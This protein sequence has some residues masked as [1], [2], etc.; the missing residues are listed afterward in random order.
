[1]SA[2]FNVLAFPDYIVTSHKTG[3]GYYIFVLAYTSFAFFLIAPLVAWS[4]NFEKKKQFEEE[5]ALASEQLQAAAATAAVTPGGKS[6]VVH[7]NATKPQPPGKASSNVM[8][9]SGNKSVAVSSLS[10][11]SLTPSHFSKVSKNTARSGRSAGFYFLRELDKVAAAEYP[12]KNPDFQSHIGGGHTVV[13]KSGTADTS[14]AS[15][16]P[17]AATTSR[18]HLPSPS[19]KN[20]SSLVLDVGGRRWKNRR[21]IGRVDVIHHAIHHERAGSS[22]SGI[23]NSKQ[24]HSTPGTRATTSKQHH[25][26]RPGSKGMSDIASSVLSEQTHEIMRPNSFLHPPLTSMNHHHRNRFI[27]RPSRSG[28]YSAASERSALS[29]IVDD[30]SPNDAADANDPGRGN[31]FVQDENGGKLIQQSTNSGLRLGHC[32]A[33][34]ESLLELTHPGEEMTRVVL[35]SFPLAMGAM[36]EAF[37]RLVTATFISQYLGTES[38]IAFLLVGLF[39]RLTSEELSGAIIDALSSFV[40]TC[41]FSEEGD[42]ARMAGQFVQHAVFLQLVLGIPLLLVWALSMEDVVFWLVQSTTI[43]SVAN[44]YAQVVVFYYLVQSLSRTCTVV[45]HICG[46]EHFESI[47]DFATSTM[48]LIVVAFVVATVDNATLMTVGYIQVLIGI[49]GAVAKVMFPVMRGWMK[50]FRGGMIGELAIIRSPAALKQLARA[51]VPLFLGT[52]LEY[53]EWEV[54][55]LFLRHLGPAEVATWA[56]LGA[57]WDVLE[58]MTEG[59]GEAA[60]IQVTFLLAAAQPERARKLANSAI[61][62]AVVQAMVVTS[63]LYMGGR[64]LAVLFSSDYTIQH[65]LNNTIALI[66]LANVTMSFSQ[67]SWSLIGAQGRF[68]LA[69]SVFFFSRWIVTIPLALVTIF[70]F[71]LDLN[72]VSG[73]LVVGYSTASC[74]LTFIVL[75]SD[76]ERLARVMQDMN[77][78]PEKGPLDMLDGGDEDND[79]GD[80]FEDF[81]DDSDS[82]D[83]FGI[84]GKFD[85]DTIAGRSKAAQESE[86]SGRSKR[87]KQGKDGSAMSLR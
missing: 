29:S 10:G 41:L 26:K 56:L 6:K 18:L 63:G 87:S 78:A 47:I 72:S 71:F 17:S 32:S 13:S 48:Q 24:G 51:V 31:I 61:Y 25:R 54:L 23:S 19:T 11:G 83:G 44:D 38:M 86:V 16:S 84:G 43:A 57:I 20:L 3:P 1:M 53:G 7:T 5:L 68:R 69:T 64:Y 66:G 75:R 82:S 79:D 67:I 21:P 74:A 8:S 4:R 55:T 34:F 36:S 58:A 59:I 37:Y 60:A 45:F 42:A 50:P 81:D 15:Q 49:A 30:I 40:Q 28:S 39:V 62:L 14:G 12:D 85:D 9:V 70:A 65:L 35:S 52:V 2:A 33:F 76:W 73:A 80:P 22:V 77:T 27:R 46:H